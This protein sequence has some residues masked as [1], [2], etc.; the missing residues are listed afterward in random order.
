MQTYEEVASN[1]FD[2]ACR[3]KRMYVIE[4]LF[5]RVVVIIP[6]ISNRIFAAICCMDYLHML[7]IHYN[8]HKVVVL[9][10]GQ[11]DESAIDW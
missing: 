3:Q 2:I 11:G 6:Q 1:I 10:K 8:L 9:Q 4:Y 7:S 5:G